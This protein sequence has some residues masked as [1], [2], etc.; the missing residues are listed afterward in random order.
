MKEAI[1]ERAARL[2]FDACGFTTAEP[3]A[4]ASRFLA[5]IDSG[6]HGTMAY[7][8][9]TAAQR[10]DPQRALPGARSVITLAASYWLPA[11]HEPPDP[12]AQ[13][14]GSPGP[15]PPIA[16]AAVA[17]YAQ[18]ADYHVVL[19]PPLRALVDFVRDLP[20][21]DSGPLLERDLGQRGGLGFIG[22]HTNLIHPGLGNW[23]F[24]AEILTTLA[25][26]PDQPG[27]NHCGRCRR[28]LAACPTGA[29]TRPFALDA[30]RCLSY[31]TIESPGPIPVDLRPAL[32]TRVFGCDECLVACPWNR[33]ARAGRLMRDHAR[34]EIAN[35]DLLEWLALDE[36]GFRRQFAGTPLLRAKRRGLLRNVCVALGNQGDRGALPA[37]ER[38]AADPE[39]LIAEHALWAIEQLRS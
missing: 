18:F 26:E 4:S 30:R 9:R 28:C 6:Q 36:A 25:L 21:A 13:S 32:G 10:I 33:F 20:Y 23:L 5:W 7:L 34:P 35:P 16:P 24:L 31:L 15:A 19:G 12:A 17:R 38:A 11:A 37:L 39:P 8:A 27:R 14:H 2:G 1:R 3:P 22:K 29:L